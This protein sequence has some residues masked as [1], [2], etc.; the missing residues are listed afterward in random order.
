MKTLWR[1]ESH[2]WSKNGDKITEPVKLAAIRE[3][4]EKRS[5]IIIEHWHYCGSR[6]ASHRAFDDYDDFVEY[7]NSEC[8]AGDAIDVWEFSSLCRSDNKLTSGKCPNENNEVP[9][10]G[11][12]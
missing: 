5:P 7:L 9:K 4:L 11:A 6:A 1:N 2:E 3:C 10:S 12:Y 8:I